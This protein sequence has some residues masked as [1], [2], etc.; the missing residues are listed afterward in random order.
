MMSHVRT[1]PIQF[2]PGES[3]MC[4]FLFC[5]E[6]VFVLVKSWTWYLV[7]IICMVLN[8]QKDRERNLLNKRQSYLIY[9]DPVTVKCNLDS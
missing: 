9:P 2:Q 5:S 4:S 7:F 8:G 6:D 1:M 3:K